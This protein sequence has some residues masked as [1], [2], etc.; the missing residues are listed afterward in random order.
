MERRISV[1]PKYVDHLQRWSRIFRSEET[2]TNL[3]IWIPT[4]VSGIFGKM[5]SA[6]VIGHPRDRAPITW[7][8]GERRTN[9]DREFCY[10]YDYDGNT[11]TPAGL[12]T[13]DKFI[14][15]QML[16]MADDVRS[17]ATKKRRK[18]DRQA[19]DHRKEKT[20]SEQHSAKRT[21]ETN[22]L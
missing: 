5:E 7:Q 8:I 4:E 16:N 3:S 13:N 10:R 6:P 21:G 22:T 2:E 15:R 1:G 17:P 20:E 9:H 11:P 19:L 12:G 18:T 14:S